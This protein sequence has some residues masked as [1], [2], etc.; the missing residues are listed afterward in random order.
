MLNKLNLTFD[1]RIVFTNSNRLKQSFEGVENTSFVTKTLHHKD[2][3]IL[4]KLDCQQSFLNV[5]AQYFWCI[6]SLAASKFFILSICG[7][8]SYA[9]GCCSE[10]KLSILDVCGVLNTP[11]PMRSCPC[12]SYISLQGILNEFH[13]YCNS[14]FFAIALV[15]FIKFP[16]IIC[17]IYILKVKL[18]K[19]FFGNSYP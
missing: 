14:I 16:Q 1:R 9:S 18:A 6:Q 13:G 19:Q 5:C 10:A 12:S 11:L 8:S 15:K 3:A 2:S 17:A 4:S 7:G